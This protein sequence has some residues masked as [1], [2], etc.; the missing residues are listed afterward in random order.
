[1]LS[2]C[3]MVKLCYSRLAD[4][5]S[6]WLRSHSGSNIANHLSGSKD[7]HNDADVVSAKNLRG[8]S[9]TLL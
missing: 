5:N 8:L 2:L 7:L 9:H 3:A 1:M 6:E 4:T